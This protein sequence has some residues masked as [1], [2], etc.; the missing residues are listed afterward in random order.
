MSS[1]SPSAQ[2][3]YLTESRADPTLWEKEIS[4]TL[5]STVFKNPDGTN[6][7]VYYN[8]A[9]VRV[10]AA[11]SSEEDDTEYTCE[12]ELFRN[13]NSTGNVLKL[14][15]ERYVCDDLVNVLWAAKVLEETNA[16]YV[17]FRGVVYA[18]EALE[19]VF[20]DAI[21]TSNVRAN[22]LYID[23][24]VAAGGTSPLG[25]A[26]TAFRGRPFSRIVK[27]ATF[28]RGIR[29]FGIGRMD[30][31]NA[32]D[33]EEML[34]A[35]KTKS[36]MPE[37]EYL[38]L[39][40]H[41]RCS[42]KVSDLVCK[43]LGVN[44]LV[45]VTFVETYFQP[46]YYEKFTAAVMGNGNALRHFTVHCANLTDEELGDA[47]VLVCN[48][49]IESAEI[50]FGAAVSHASHLHNCSA[51]CPNSKLESFHMYR[52]GTPF[53]ET[54][55]PRIERFMD[56]I[57]QRG[58]LVSLVLDC[59]RASPVQQTIDQWLR[60]AVEVRTSRAN[61]KRPVLDTQPVKFETALEEIV[62]TATAVRKCDQ[63]PNTDT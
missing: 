50:V 8:Y 49:E 51:M 55:L 14:V 46:V 24:S 13:L 62:G 4:L 41:T 23:T 15:L 17:E 12:E 6:S 38:E 29:S 56:H 32:L 61:R 39:A 19:N 60:D 26:A 11:P 47:A 34:D 28:L 33:I 1:T 63:C 31:G 9:H 48:T 5:S 58:A 44:Q 43:L 35:L 30:E 45:G 18:S 57:R 25:A 7:G 2:L 42:E 59:D 52:D 22:G 37:L 36:C 27:N 3:P 54:A 20:F 53:P 16:R 10:H 21:F 40:F